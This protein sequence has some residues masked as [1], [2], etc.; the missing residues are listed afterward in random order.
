MKF[1]NI[2]II[3]TLLI[4]LLTSFYF[5]VKKIKEENI[6]FKEFD[7]NISTNIET[8]EEK[9]FINKVMPDFGLP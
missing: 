4:I 3:S 5:Y 9:L 7:K 8:K 1:K 2:Y 6:V